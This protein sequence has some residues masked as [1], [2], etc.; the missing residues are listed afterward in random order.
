MP[1]FQQRVRTVVALVISRWRV[2]ALWLA[3]GSAAGVAAAFLIPS[4][5][6]A[7]ASFQPEDPNSSLGGLG[8]RSLAGL[9][10]QLA[11][12]G[13]GGGANPQFFADLVSSRVILRRLA[14]SSFP[15]PDGVKPLA[16]IYGLGKLQGEERLQR[17]ERVLTK[18][19][20]GSLNFRTGVVSFQVQA[21]TPAMAYALAESTL[22]ALNDFNVRM[23]Q[24]RAA[25]QRRFAEERV[26]EAR[27]ALADAEDRTLSFQLQNRDV[28][29]P[30]LQLTLQRLKRQEDLALTFYNEMRTNLEQTRLQ[31]VRD[32]PALTIID[33]PQIPVQRAWPRRSLVAIVGALAGVAIAF[34]Q[35]LLFGAARPTV[36]KPL[37][38][39]VAGAA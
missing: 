20:S 14:A 1:V 21:N 18:K 29:A 19:L 26:A 11:G 28:S 15:S 5:Y 27:Q 34:T 4:V 9:A 38:R 7:D 30:G 36:Q 6:V 3:L 23:R 13:I 10:S 2:V 8:G 16:E 39:S 12:G 37:V 31:E 22:A 17:T 24:S 33:A 25:A 32:T 35:L